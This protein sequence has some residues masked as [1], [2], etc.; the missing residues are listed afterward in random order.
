[1]DLI[2]L[3]LAYLAGL[4]ASALG[5]P[6]LVGYL[7]VGFALSGLGLTPGA[8]LGELAHL[9]VLILLF[10]VGLKLRLRS[11]LRR[12]VW[13]GGLVHFALVA[14][15]FSLGLSVLGLTWQPA[16]FLGA[17]LAF[18]STVLAAKVLEEKRELGA[19]HGRVALSVLI[20][21]DLIAV[22]LMALAG[23]AALS[24]WALALVA[25]VFVRVPL[26]R[27]LAWSGHA[28]LLL[29]FGVALALTGATLF[30]AV[31][32]SGELGALAVGA[33]LAGDRRSAELGELLWGVKEVFLVAFFVEVGLAGFPG[34]R[35]V[36]GSLLLL[37]LIPLKAGL[38]FFLFVRSNLRARNAFLAALALASYS[39]FALIAAGVGVETGLLSPDWLAT[40]A[41]GVA[42]SFAVAAPLNRFAHRLFDRL[43]VGLIRFE[44][45]ARHPDQQPLSLGSARFLIVGMGRTGAAAYARLRDAGEAVVGLDSDP[46]RLEWCR[47]EGYRVRYGDAEDPE[48]WAELRLDDIALV[49]LTMP[50]LEAKLRTARHLEK[51]GFGG[52]LV[53][54]CLFPEDEA[55]L[56]EAGVGLLFNP[57]VE[58]G[59]RLAGLGLEALAGSSEQDALKV[60]A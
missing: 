27:L 23:G 60:T 56:K 47:A 16:A 35:A 46:A 43:E 3:G 8:L 48:L 51:R 21:Q 41:L 40:L 50:D 32:L 5:L 17:G 34:A 49:A 11:L 6:P 13:G 14:G 38:F 58:A 30:E 57:F 2:W 45:G 55:I 31:G 52:V 10:T 37:L 20:L 36:A 33:A 4:T 15:L 1:M 19:F 25:L 12:E 7:G 24:P 53:A 59:V 39:E 44:T 42:L 9:G 22:L 18:S 29:L 28:E 54:T 26:A